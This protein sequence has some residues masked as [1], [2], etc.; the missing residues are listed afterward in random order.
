MYQSKVSLEIRLFEVR[1]IVPEL[2]RG[3]LTLVYNRGRRQGADVATC[4]RTFDRV[5]GSFS[6]NKNLFKS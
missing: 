6:Q 5:R 3:Q 2:F 1:I 4:A